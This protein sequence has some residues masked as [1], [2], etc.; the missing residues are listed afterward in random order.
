VADAKQIELTE[1][2]AYLWAS[3][4]DDLAVTDAVKEV[5]RKYRQLRAV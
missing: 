4:D 5:F 3:L 2:D 1:H